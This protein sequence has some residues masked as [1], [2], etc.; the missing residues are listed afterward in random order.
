MRLCCEP[1]LIGS[2]FAVCSLLGFWE[3]CFKPGGPFAVK[4]ERRSRQ[5]SVDKGVA[6]DS[7]QSHPRLCGGD[8]P[9]GAQPQTDDDSDHQ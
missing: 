5:A 4:D 9:N 2:V 3:S 7:Y 1:D 6:G 8:V